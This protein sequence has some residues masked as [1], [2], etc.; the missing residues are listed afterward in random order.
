MYITADLSYFIVTTQLNLNWNWEDRVSG[1]NL[2]L[3]KRIGFPKKCLSN[4]Y[5]QEPTGC[6]QVDH[7]DLAFFKE[8]YVVPKLNPK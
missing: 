7:F 4:L 6:W 3:H 8:C 2:P 5:F 1:W